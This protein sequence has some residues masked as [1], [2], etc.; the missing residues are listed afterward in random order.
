[1]PDFWLTAKCLAEGS[2]GISGSDFCIHIIKKKLCT[3]YKAQ[4]K[5]ENYKRLLRQTLIFS[6][7]RSLD[8]RITIFNSLIK[9]LLHC[10]KEREAA[11]KTISFL[12]HHDDQ[13]PITKNSLKITKLKLGL[14]V[15]TISWKS[16]D[17]SH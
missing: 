15:R 1:M 7:N 17:K 10:S 16:R 11:S 8:L 6:H 13:Q 12:W 3:I 4:G 2:D 14:A 5:R 9:N